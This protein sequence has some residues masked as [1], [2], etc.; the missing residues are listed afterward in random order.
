MDIIYCKFIDR[1]IKNL[2]LYYYVFLFV[3]LELQFQLE[4]Y[5]R[6]M[7]GGQVF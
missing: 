2:M 6:I 3:G 1:L 4:T 5:L 7:N